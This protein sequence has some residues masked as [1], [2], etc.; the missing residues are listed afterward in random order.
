MILKADIKNVLANKNV[1]I[2]V[3]MKVLKDH[4]NQDLKNYYWYIGVVATTGETFGILIDA[5]NGNI[6][7]KKV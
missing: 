3:V 1:N 6:I 7:A 2:E 5:N 4:S